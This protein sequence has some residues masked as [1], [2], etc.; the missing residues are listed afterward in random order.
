MRQPALLHGSAYGRLP[1][2]EGA[3]ASACDV[4][5][6]LVF[7]E[8]VEQLLRGGPRG[9]PAPRGG[10]HGIAHLH[11]GHHGRTE[12]HRLRPQAPHARRLDLRLA[13]RDERG[14]GGLAEVAV[15]LGDHRV[16]DVPCPDLGGQARDRVLAGAQESGVLGEYHQHLQGVHTHDHAPGP[17]LGARHPRGPARRTALAVLEPYRHRRRASDIRVGEPH[18]ADAGHLREHAQLLWRLREQ[19]HRVHRPQGGHQLGDLPGEGACRQA[20]AALQGLRH[21]G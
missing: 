8:Q 7:Q 1:W 2:R 9:A 6:G 17:G 14:L 10:R 4:Q 5:L 21:E 13:V 19:L 3:E 12:G 18:H 15:L 16:G 11:L 20:A